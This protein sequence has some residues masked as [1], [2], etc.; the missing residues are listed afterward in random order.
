MWDSRPLERPFVGL[1]R[2]LIPTKT[3]GFC[4]QSSWS[5]S[6][7]SFVRSFHVLRTVVFVFCRLSSLLAITRSVSNFLWI[8][9]S[10]LLLMESGECV[11]SCITFSHRS[12]HIRWAAS[13]MI[14]RSRRERPFAGF[15][16]AWSSSS[17]PWLVFMCS[18]PTPRT[19][20]SFMTGHCSLSWGHSFSASSHTNF[21][22]FD[23]HSIR[24]CSRSS[25]A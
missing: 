24:M 5:C 18:S 6:S 2:G 22:V 25:F 9:S 13:P 21:L 11:F 14:M 23:G 3:L 20:P 19:V 4:I 12:T 10:H 17:S 8:L 7:D 15:L 16:C 1:H